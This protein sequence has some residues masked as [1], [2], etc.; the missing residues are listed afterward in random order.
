M[1]FKERG[2]V[3]ESFECRGQLDNLPA[4]TIGNGS[5]H[6]PV[7]LHEGNQVVMTFIGMF[8]YLFY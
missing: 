5:E 2:P 6:D 7:L 8:M 1:I 4:G 3:F